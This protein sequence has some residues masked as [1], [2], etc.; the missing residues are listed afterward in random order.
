MP[1][2]LAL[3]G[4]FFPRFILFLGWI[5]GFTSRGFEGWVWPLLGF[6]FMPFTTLAYALGHAY[7]EGVRGIWL[8]VLIIA[9]VLDLGSGGTAVASK[10]K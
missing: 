9:V 10:S 4:L 7:G 2:L 6:I 8:V 1:C 3:L 5:F